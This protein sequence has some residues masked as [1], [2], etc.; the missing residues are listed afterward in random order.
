MVHPPA[1]KIDW[2]AELLFGFNILI[3]LTLLV[4]LV[5]ILAGILG[6]DMGSTLVWIG[7]ISLVYG[8]RYLAL[9]LGL[10]NI[11]IV[12]FFLPR[13]PANTKRFGLITGICGVLAGLALWL[14]IIFAV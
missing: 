1:Q 12:A 9:P 7:T 5:S 11:I 6:F 4:T 8:L 14:L 3:I 13:R 2:P 10:L